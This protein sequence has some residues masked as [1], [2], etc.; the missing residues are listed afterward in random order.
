VRDQDRS[1][2]RRTAI[3]D[4]LDDA[5]LGR[6]LAH[7]SV[8]DHP[9]GETL[10]QQGDPAVF[11]Y[12]VLEGW[13]KVYRLTRSGDEAVVGVFTRGQ[14]FAEAAGFL[15][16][17]YPAAAETVADSRLLRVPCRDLVTCIRESPDIAL[18]MLASTSRHL[19]RLVMQIEQLK[20]RTGTQRVAEFL[21][22]LCPVE[23][24]ACT[25]G[26]PYDKALIAGRLG[27]KPESLSRAFAR[28]REVGVVID[29]NTA[30]ISDVAALRGFVD[31]ELGGYESEMRHG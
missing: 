4:G 6:L 5:L 21:A 20:A 24:G 26:L 18:A 31:D 2:I 9:R 16:A 28:L 25:I 10:F 8:N 29:H 3:F 30:A 14:S 19:H 15:E 7:A 1:L 17:V 13:V 12:V 27:M 22:G 23:E 11:F